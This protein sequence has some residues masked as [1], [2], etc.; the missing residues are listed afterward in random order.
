MDDKN[1]KKY[2][3]ENRLEFGGKNYY[4]YYYYIYIYNKKRVQLRSSIV[5][6]TYLPT[7]VQILGQLRRLTRTGLAYYDD[8]LILSNNVQ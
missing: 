4:Y 2:R 8:D 1:K 5:N 6:H 3:R 7:F